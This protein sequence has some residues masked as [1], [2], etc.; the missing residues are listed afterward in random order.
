ML[1][2]HSG[3]FEEE[4]VQSKIPVIIDYFADWCGP[5]KQLAPI[6]E[7]VAEE[8][9]D[10]VKFAK[11]NVDAHSEFAQANGVMSI[12]C[13]IIYKDGKEVARMVG[14]QTEDALEKQLKAIL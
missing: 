3:N 13:L 11:C 4:V 5:C 9:E 14:N 8:M 7:K 1:E 10:E 12:P 2:V 6:F